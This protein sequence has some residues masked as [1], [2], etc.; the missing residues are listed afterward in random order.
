MPR[1]G[2]PTPTTQD[3]LLERK[4]SQ[5]IKIR[6]E[7]SA[8]LVA[9]LEVQHSTSRLSQRMTSHEKY[10]QT[11]PSPDSKPFPATDAQNTF[12]GPSS[13]KQDRN[14]LLLSG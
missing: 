11:E 3:A 14:S 13:R 4:E 9:S 5:S 7:T 1:L 10:S 8:P 12:P 2:F 6:T